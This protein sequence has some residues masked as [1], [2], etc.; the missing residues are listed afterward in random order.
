MNSVLA[1]KLGERDD[2]EPNTSFLY[3]QMFGNPARSS[4]IAND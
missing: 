2:V 1:R 3:N 4:S